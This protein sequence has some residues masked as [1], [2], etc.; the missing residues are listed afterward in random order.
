M[1]NDMISA[2]TT[3]NPVSSAEPG[4]PRISS[5][6]RLVNAG[7]S[8]LLLVVV[9]GVLEAVSRSG[10]VSILLVPPPSAIFS[11]LWGGLTSGIYWLPLFDS[12]WAGFSGF[13]IAALL[14]FTIGGLLAS[15]P[16][17]E[18]ILFPYV[19]AFQS[20]PMIAIAPLIIIW[21][22]FGIQS[23]IVVV[24]VVCFFPILVNT[25]QGLRLRDRDRQELAIALGAT[26]WQ[27]FRYIRLPGSM[28]YVFAGLHVSAIFALIG[29][30]VA[31]FVGARGGIGTMMNEQRALFNVPGVFAILII[32]MVVG[33]TVNLLMKAL[34]RR[35]T[36]WSREKN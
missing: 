34:E 33:L 28:P 18:R 3:E 12:L 20:T 15:L 7:L 35:V 17:L 1:T 10:L 14:G 13:L 24:T 30:I 11:T 29:A 31:E 5:R 26:R 27:V 19:V 8:V 21:V 2:V 9:L 25:L 16:R 23:K 32:L 22:G 36:F 6:T 4:E